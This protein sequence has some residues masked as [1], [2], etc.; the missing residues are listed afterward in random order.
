[1]NSRA[2]DGAGTGGCACM[3]V[4]FPAAVDCGQWSVHTAEF[5]DP[6][7]RARD[8]ADHPETA[9]TGFVRIPA[10]GFSTGRNK[11]FR[12][13]HS[14]M[15]KIE[16]ELSMEIPKFGISRLV[17]FSDHNRMILT[18]VQS[19]PPAKFRPKPPISERAE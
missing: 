18:D 5:T 17:F 6:D 9:D 15:M 13:N 12:Q 16:Y 4:G 14:V 7:A 11:P 10:R 3:G 19:D 8:S 1:M 2:G